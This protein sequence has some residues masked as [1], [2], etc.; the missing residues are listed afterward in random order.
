MSKHVSGTNQAELT[1][2]RD[3]SARRKRAV[4][5]KTLR[6]SSTPSSSTSR[7]F[8]SRIISADSFAI[9]TAVPP[10]SMERIQFPTARIAFLADRRQPE[11]VKSSH[12]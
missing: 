1:S 10:D 3:L 2:L 11:P 5:A 4:L 12:G 7:L 6:L 9:S 8:S